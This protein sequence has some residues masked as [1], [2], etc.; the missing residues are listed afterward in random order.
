MKAFQ[1]PAK[2][3]YLDLKRRARVDTLAPDRPSE[4]HIWI[5]GTGGVIPADYIARRL[6]TKVDAALA[7]SPLLF[8]LIYLETLQPPPMTRAQLRAL[9][10]TIQGG[11]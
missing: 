10:L 5:D 11:I 2:V 8:E 6:A 7:R 9:L 4:D 1:T 3:Y